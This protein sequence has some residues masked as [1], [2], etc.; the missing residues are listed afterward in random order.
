[1]S[2]PKQN[3]VR[4]RTP[5]PG[6]PRARLAL[7]ALVAV[8][9]MTLATSPALAQAPTGPVDPAG[10]PPGSTGEASKVSSAGR[11]PTDGR[12]LEAFMDGYFAQ[13]LESYK[14]PGATVS[15]VKDGEVLFTKGYGQADVAKDEPVVADETLFRVGSVSKLFTSTAVMQLVEEGKLDLDKDVNRYLDDV[16]IPDTYPGRPV[17]LRNLLTH[18]AGFEQEFTGTGAR[19]AAD[20]EPL[21]EYLSGIDVPARVRPPGEVTAYSNYGMALAG[22]V[23]EE[24]SGMP[25]A[26]YVEENITGPLGMDGTT[27]AQ[28]PAPRL[29]DRLSTGYKVEGGEP[30][31]GSFEFIEEAPAGSVSSTAT[32]MARFMIA[33][34]QNGRYGDARILDEATAREMQTRQFSNDGRLNGMGLGFYEQ[35]VNGERA[36]AHGGNTPLFHSLL[37]LLPEENVGIFVS[38]NS[39]GE[40]GDRAEYELQKALMD[41]YYPGPPAPA[42]EDPAEGASVE[43]ASGDAER[44]AG[45]YRSTRG[46]LTSLEK[47]FALLGPASVTA[48]EDGS[49]TTSG[50]MKQDLTAT[51]Q[52]WVQ[53]G[54]MVFRAEGSDERLAFRE[55]E[56]RATYLAT[57]AD[58]T[59]AYEKV[60]SYGSARLHLGLLGCNLAVFLLTALV[61]PAGALT[62]RWYGRRYRKLHGEW[63]GKPEREAGGARL[64]RPLAWAFS[65]LALLLAGAVVLAATNPLEILFY[66]DSP[67][68]AAVRV[69]PYPVAALA[70]GVIVFAALSWKRRYWGLLGRAHYSLVALAALT[71]IALLG[72]YN[73]LGP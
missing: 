31:A 4:S 58:P 47:V 44:V 7:L 73:L 5:L 70:V 59:S 37:T 51:E 11:G 27:A 33:Q 54:P 22:R 32:D 17:T 60:P 42:A 13:Q 53:D 50:V 68:L 9:A 43:G 20:F 63:G 18:T 8:A 34:L 28:P 16:E 1:M 49:I 19:G 48:N 29:R 64:A 62:S 21:G 69:L 30:A 65:A 39:Y 26:R 2:P 25:F 72:Y 23:V 67:V 56:G 57:D 71:F 6:A 15:V 36:I 45:S 12:E 66:D 35:T 38:Y 40:G 55:G 52:R 61:W 46:N 41:R 3:T 24:A 10:E 14:I